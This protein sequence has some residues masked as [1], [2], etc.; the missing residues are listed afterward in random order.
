MLDKTFTVAYAPLRVSGGKRMFTF[1]KTFI[2]G[3]S[4]VNNARDG[5]C[6]RPSMYWAKNRWSARRRCFSGVPAQYLAQDFAKLQRVGSPARFADGRRDFL[7][8]G[9]LL[10]PSFFLSLQTHLWKPC[11]WKHWDN[12]LLLFIAAG[13]RNGF[14]FCF[15]VP[16]STYGAYSTFVPTKTDNSSSFGA[17]PLYLPVWITPF[18]CLS[19]L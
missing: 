5:G 17:A 18:F 9:G 14:A 8:A 2:G 16:S 19:A 4:L 3:I 6:P 7:P 15:A 13:F 12:A 10:V 11:S 1:P